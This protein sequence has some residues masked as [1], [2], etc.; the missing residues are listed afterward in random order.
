[1]SPNRG[2]I[3]KLHSCAVKAM[4][5]KAV[6]GLILII[7]ILP[8]A[9]VLTSSLDN[10]VEFIPD[11]AFYYFQVA[12]NILN[13]FGSSF[14]GFNPTDGYH[15]LWMALILPF[16]SFVR[17]PILLLRIVIGI[18]ILLS[19]YSAL[20]L[21][22]LL[23]K[24]TR[25]WWIAAIGMAFYFLNQQ[26]TLS[27]L[28]ALET[29]LS[30]FL[31]VASLLVLLNEDTSD[32]LLSRRPEQVGVL[33]GLLFLA[34]TDNIFYLV[35]FLLLA[36]HRQKTQVR[37]QS[38]IV[39]AVVLSLVVGPWFI[40]HW[41][42]FG[43]PWQ[44][45]AL[46]VP[47]VFHENSIFSGSTD[48]QLL[49]MSLKQLYGFVFVNPQVFLGFFP[50]F[51]QI[52]FIYCSL[53]I[54][55]KARKVNPANFRLGNEFLLVLLALWGGGLI[56]VIVHTSIRWYPRAWY[57]D[58]LIILASI[59]FSL[60]LDAFDTPRLSKRV[61]IA[62]FRKSSFVDFA[63]PLLAGVGF[64]AVVLSLLTIS[65]NR[66]INSPP[67]PYQVE[68][69][70]AAKWLNTEELDHECA[71]AFNAGIMAFFSHRCVVNLDG[72]INNAAYAAITHQNLLEFMRRSSLTYYLDYDPLMLQRY[73][74]FLGPTTGRVNM[75]AIRQIDR[76][77]A[78]WEDSEIKVYRLDWL[79]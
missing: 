1:M 66:V 67:Y 77:N 3:L 48:W 57:F 14:D 47:Y 56:L 8:R 29:A 60:A 74:P 44:V 43:S 19:V 12:R 10:L 69:L 45:S 18:G 21:Y 15:P 75:V 7:G 64:A 6:L 25:R 65:T 4:T 72:A 50:Y 17:D 26:S 61:K 5:K 39:M 40:W 28:D 2:I 35:A 16:V 70:D 38:S 78:S 68:M 49:V 36:L 71:G 23:R 55:Y 34:R 51:Y 13:G 73:A 24:N 9:R 46:A 22:S 53:A 52:A 62:L 41:V 58:Q 31:F 30:S 54:Y 11:D 33:F 42:Q 79:Y 37:P 59:T 63:I 27:S 76:P 32:S 20:L